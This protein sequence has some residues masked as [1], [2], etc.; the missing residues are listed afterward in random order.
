MEETPKIVRLR[1]NVGDSWNKSFTEQEKKKEKISEALEIGKRPSWVSLS[2]ETS[3]V[4]CKG[5]WIPKSGEKSGILGF[6]IR[7]TAQGIRNPLTI[8]I[9]NPSSTEKETGNPLPDI[10]NLRRGIL[11]GSTTEQKNGFAQICSLQICR[12]SVNTEE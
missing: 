4:S 10:W 5:I 11:I 7:N 12:K 1:W 6:G 8:K 3:V 2:T 9:H